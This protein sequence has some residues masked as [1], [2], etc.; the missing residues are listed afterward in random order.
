M[1]EFEKMSDKFIQS[2]ID[3][4]NK[5]DAKNGYYYGT[6]YREEKYR[7]EQLVKEAKNLL[8]EKKYAV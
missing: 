4:F 6:N 3:Y 8:M 2:Q 5:L 7:R 1:N